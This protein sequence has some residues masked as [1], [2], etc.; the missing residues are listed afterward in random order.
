MVS[1]YVA[2]F[3]AIS[4]AVLASTG[5]A[6]AICPYDANCLNNPYGAGNPYAPNGLMNPYSA[7]GSP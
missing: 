4:V 5:A 3:V 7:Y 1:R 6:L 2:L